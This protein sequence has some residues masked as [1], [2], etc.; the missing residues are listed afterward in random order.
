MVNGAVPR[1]ARASIGGICYHV[2]NRGNAR[3]DVFHKDD[4]RSPHGPGIQAATPRTPTNR[5]KRRRMSP[6]PLQTA[7][8]VCRG[9]C[10]APAVLVGVGVPTG[11]KHNRPRETRGGRSHQDAR[12]HQILIFFAIGL[13]ILLRKASGRLFRSTKLCFA[14]NF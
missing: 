5:G 14:K 7:G 10:A 3:Q 13:F 4:Y 11:A 2:L 12:R 8:T 6:F 9:D 1:T